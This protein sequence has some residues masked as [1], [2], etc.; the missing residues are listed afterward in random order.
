VTSARSRFPLARGLKFFLLAAVTLVLLLLVLLATVFGLVRNDTERLAGLIEVI[1]STVLQRELEVGELL[2]ADLG[3]DTYLLATD[4]SLSNPPGAQYAD[5]ARVGRLQLRINLPSIW[6]DGPIMFQQL[7]ITDASANIYLVSE[8]HAASWDFWPDVAPAEDVFLEEADNS[9]LEPVFPVLFLD[10]NIHGSRLKV[11]GPSHEVVIGLAEMSLR[12][13]TPDQPVILDIDG[14]VN[15]I[16]LTVDGSFGP[17]SSLITLNNMAMEL[18]IGWGELRVDAHGSIA[19]LANLAGPDL[20]LNITAPDARPLLEVLGVPGGEDGPIE[21]AA[22]VTDAGPGFQIDLNGFMGQFNL[23]LAGK[24]GKPR[25]F[26]D[27]DVRFS[28]SGSSMAEV[29]TLFELPGFSD[30]PYAVSAQLVRDGKELTIHDGELSAG[31]GHLVWGSYFPNYPQIDNWEASLQGEKF[32]LGLI[33]LLLGI[34]DIPAI[35]YS[36]VGKLSATEDGL[37]VVHLA[38]DSAEGNLTLKGVIGQGPDYLGTRFDVDLVGETLSQPAAWLRLPELPGIPY[39]FSADIALDAGGWKLQR[40]K[41]TSAGVVFG[42]SGKIA[43]L[44]TDSSLDLT[45][46]VTSD[47]LRSSLESLGYP[48][49]GLK[50]YAVETTATVSGSVDKLHLDQLMAISGDSR[51]RLSGDLGDVLNASSLEL[52]ADIESPDILQLVPVMAAGTKASLPVAARGAL[53]FTE[54][55]LEVKSAQG[56]MGEARVSFNGG[57]NLLDVYKKSYL[58]LHGE[59]ESL[60]E[61]LG[62]WLREPMPD[63]PFQL[64]VDMDLTESQLSVDKLVASAGDANLDASFEVGDVKE[65]ANARGTIDLSGPNSAPLVKLLGLDSELLAAPYHLSVNLSKS[66]DSIT[67]DPVRLEWGK[68]DYAGVI[69]VHIAD[70]PEVKATLHSDY[71]SLASVL[72]DVEALAAEEARRAET[73]EEQRKPAASRL[74]RAQLAERVI[75]NNTLDFSWLNQFKASIDYSVDVLHFREDAT[76]TAD[77]SFSIIDGTLTSRKIAWE[78]KF[79]AG[80]ANLMLQATDAG[81]NADVY[82]DIQRLP[83]LLLLGGVPKHNPDSIYRARLRAHGDSMKSMANNASGAI[84]FV[85][86]GGRL[87]NNSLDLILGDFFEEIFDR[88]NPFSDTDSYTRIECHAGAATIAN[89]A[90]RLNPGLVIRTKKMDI[91]SSGSLNL[92]NEKLDLEFNTRSRKGIGISASKAITPYFKIGG[93]LAYPSMA[94]NVEGAAVSGGAAVATGGLSIL[95]SGL[96]D[97]WVATARNPCK[98]LTTQVSERQKSAYQELLYGIESDPSP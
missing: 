58:Q 80:K 85:G 14:S 16:P 68:S 77:V 73:A 88:I 38:L 76:T 93:T 66:A 13:T 98:Q 2:E 12:E 44:S 46:R 10:G 1:G 17:S 18:A 45:V 4:V 37:E 30:Q 60:A 35:G 62:P 25:A 9:D 54:N 55:L 40:S 87:D 79:S 20:H 91:V 59:G 49:A 57:I 90:M 3:W 39:Q 42:A 94:L 19:D 34:P 52:M 95:A 72:P 5:F 33:G 51:F 47:N 26:D 67:L 74:T 78:G 61:T 48:V 84:A 21:F 22:K 65:L 32:N 69:E 50:D 8:R 6:R 83:L 92:D 86:G 96:W 29:A 11:I 71:I 31:Q 28:L 97:R 63:T 43:R 81:V 75:P 70:V 15:N 64:S 53:V 41:F 24:L 36:V 89:G 27:I 7:D 23:A 82:L 56:S